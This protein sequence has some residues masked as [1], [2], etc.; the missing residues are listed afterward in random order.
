LFQKYSVPG[1]APWDDI[2]RTQRVWH[3]RFFNVRDLPEMLVAGRE[4][5]F[6]TWFHNNEAVNSRAFANE[7]EE[8]YARAYSMPGALRAGFEY[9]RAFPTDMIANREFAKRKLTMPVLGIGGSI[10]DHLRYVATDVRG[11]NIENCGHWVA[12]EQ[13]EAVIDA[14]LAFLPPAL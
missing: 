10:D 11:V 8:T 5:E 14:R 6:L 13:P 9:Y 7:A 12:E 1:I 2:V 3:F 4:R